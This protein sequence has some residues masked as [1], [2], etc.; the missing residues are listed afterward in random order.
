MMNKKMMYTLVAMVVII[1]VVVG[2]AGGYMLMNS[3]G[4]NT[5]KVADATSLQYDV[6]VTYQGTTTLSKFAGKNLGTSDVMLRIDL[7]GDNQANYTTVIKG[8]DQTAWRSTNGN[9]TDVSTTYNTIWEIGCGNQWNNNVDALANW[10]G[11]GDCTYT[12]SVG[13][14]YKIYNVV[15]NPTLDDSL[16]QHPT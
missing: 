15:I 4:G 14:S 6:D 12:D 13:T 10:S 16:F 11:T 5:V 7:S 9:W 2:S 8:G 1:V 3:G